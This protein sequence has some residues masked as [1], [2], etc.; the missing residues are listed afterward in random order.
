MAELERAKRRQRRALSPAQVERAFKRGL[1][2]PDE[3]RDRLRTLGY[4]DKDVDILMNLWTQE[5]AP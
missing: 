1:L 4:A 2:S 5:M 3:T